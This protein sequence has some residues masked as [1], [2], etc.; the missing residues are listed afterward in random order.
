MRAATAIL[1]ALLVISVVAIGCAKTT[2]QTAQPAA[3]GAGAA[4]NDAGAKVEQQFDNSLPNTSIDSSS[5]LDSL[6]SDLA[7][8]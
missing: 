7:I 6:D 3:N 4:A 5:D 2:P 1:L 8:Q